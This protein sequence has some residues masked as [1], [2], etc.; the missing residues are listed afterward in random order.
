VNGYFKTK[1]PIQWK[2]AIMFD[3]DNREWLVRETGLV[4]TLKKLNS[5]VFVG[6]TKE[7]FSMPKTMN[8]HSPWTMERQMAVD[9]CPL[10][11]MV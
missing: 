8:G 4:F 6:R 3:G 9:W 11:L 7:G 10:W 1:M 2:I 5:Q